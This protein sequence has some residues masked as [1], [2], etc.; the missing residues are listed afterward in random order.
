MDDT[1]DYDDIDIELVYMYSTLSETAERSPESIQ[2]I[3]LILEEYGIKGRYHFINV[4]DS[5]NIPDQTR[6]ENFMRQHTDDVVLLVS[7]L[8]SDLTYATS[9]YLQNRGYTNYLILNCASTVSNSVLDQ[10]RVIRIIPRDGS[11]A[12]LYKAVF[13]SVQAVNRVLL[14]DETNSWARELAND[15]QAVIPNIV[16][17]NIN[18]IINGTVQLP[19]GS[20]SI[21]TLADPAMG[22]LLQ[23]LPQRTPDVRLVLLG[24]SDS[25]ISPSTAMELQYLTAWNTK[26]I[27]PRTNTTA[28][29][30]SFVERTG[31][32]NIS[33]TLG[34]V[35][36]VLQLAAY[37][38]YALV[39][40]SRTIH[41]SDGQINALHLL[42][43]IR[44][45]YLG[46]GL[47][48]ESMDALSGIYTVVHFTEVG[49]PPTAIDLVGVSL[50]E[51]DD[52]VRMYIGQEEQP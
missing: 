18:S 49:L 25:T 48:E 45:Y 22:R 8:G 32:T 28:T 30:G 51:T 50:L 47:D 35:V 4:T 41:N 29:I 38:K 16:R 20:M 24:E 17:Y 19:Q 40:D 37:I 5:N 12:L 36:S 14:V 7:S 52:T 6:L 15:I 9:E 2:L 23:I 1:E 10:P 27:I 26:V 33:N 43:A 31:Y 44:N 46:I 13:N 3:P 34:S 42:P 39:H 21:I 11:N